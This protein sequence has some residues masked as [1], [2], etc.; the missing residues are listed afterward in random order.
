MNNSILSS[1]VFFERI[2][3]I[4]PSVKKISSIYSNKKI[5]INNISVSIMFYF[6]YYI[7]YNVL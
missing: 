4:V 1:N 7:V 3:F 5:P 6:I 2:H